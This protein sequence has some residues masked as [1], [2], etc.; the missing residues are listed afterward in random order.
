MS[1]TDS[2][3]SEVTDEVRRDRLFMLMRRYGWIGIVA[4]LG[5]VGGAAW[6][7]WR[8]QSAQ[9]DARA[10]GDQLLAA[11]QAENAGT[12]LQGL[13]AEGT[14]GALARIGAAAQSLRDGKPEEA[15]ST[16]KAVAADAKLP[17]NLRD[18]ALLKAVIIGGTAMPEAERTAA[19][20]ELA[21]PGAPYRLMAVEQQAIAALAQGDT[22]G[23]I[24]KAREIL[25]DSALTP[26]LQQRASELI[27]ALGADP[28]TP[29]PVPAAV[30]AQ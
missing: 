13:P 26:G 6:Y 10:F 2:F 17:R 22:D 28:A 21:K 27:V 19:L 5:I 12:L 15:V 25:M 16:L 8:K 1:E 23:A 14:Q 3:I 20:T 9:E 30:P 7:E 29:T 24:A 11:L 18:L 4:V